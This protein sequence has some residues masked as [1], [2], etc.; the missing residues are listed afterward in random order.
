MQNKSK[1]RT[2]PQD[3]INALVQTLLI[4]SEFEGASECL[5]A[6]GT[7]RNLSTNL[8]ASL[9][10]GSEHHFSDGLRQQLVVLEAE[11]VERFLTH[12]PDTHLKVLKALRE[13]NTAASLS[14]QA[15]N[16]TVELAV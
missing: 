2:S 10:I 16:P 3:D 4:Q 6:G 11:A 5:A 8:R 1:A 12:G 14:A 13:G 7:L 9:Q 15:L